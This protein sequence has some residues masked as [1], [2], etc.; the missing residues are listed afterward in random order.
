MIILPIRIG[1]EAAVEPVI[2]PI[3]PLALP[4]VPVDKE[5]PELFWSVLMPFK[6]KEITQYVRTEPQLNKLKAMVPAVAEQVEL[7]CWKP[8]VLS[9]PLRSRS[10]AVGV[11]TKT[12]AVPIMNVWGPAVA[13]V[14]AL[15]GTVAIQFPDL[16]PLMLPISPAELPGFR[17]APVQETVL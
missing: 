13:V 6:V 12:G 5:V 14:A 4:V 2:L 15:S 1:W 17:S 16:A 11:E 7:Y 9:I 8:I 3:T 10:M